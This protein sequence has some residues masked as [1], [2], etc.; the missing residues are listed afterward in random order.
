MDYGTN[1][2]GCRRWRRPTRSAAIPR[3]RAPDPRR[4]GRVVDEDDGPCPQG[5]IGSLRY[6]SP[7][8]PTGYRQSVPGATSRFA[9]GWF[10]P[11]DIGFIA[12]DGQIVVKGRIDDLIDMG[13]VKVYPADVE[14]CLAGHPEVVEAAVVGIPDRLRGTAV[15]AAVVL[16][17]PV[18]AQDL[19]THCHS[20]L[21]AARSPARMTVLD[22]LPHN[23]MGK[24]D[25]VALRRLLADGTGAG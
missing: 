1:E 25:R 9:G 22:A 10:Y 20:A 24:I 16:R 17:S 15:T 21:G 19:L 3:R 4:R 8:F 13:G 18:P 12:A 7:L 14:D 11:G 23:A 5:T 2:V 6:R